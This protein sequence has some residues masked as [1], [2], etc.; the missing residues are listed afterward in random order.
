MDG[1]KALRATSRRH[2]GALL[3][4]TAAPLDVAVDRRPRGLGQGQ[5]I[6]RSISVAMERFR[7]DRH[8]TGL[9][10]AEAGLIR[11]LG[12]ASPLAGASKAPG[13]QAPRDPGSMRPAEDPQHLKEQRLIAGADVPAELA[14]KAIDHRCGAGTGAPESGDVGV[15]RRRSSRCTAPRLMPRMGVDA[16]PACP[17]RV[18]R[19]AD[20]APVERSRRLPSH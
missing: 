11:S 1:S 13:Q 9:R 18:W 7:P 10:T 17:R 2:A 6:A 12:P 15:Q 3:L 4:T 20:C 14:L 5:T 19:D 16:S 8:G